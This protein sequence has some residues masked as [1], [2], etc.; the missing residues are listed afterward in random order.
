[1]KFT[2]LMITDYAPW[3][4]MTPDQAAALENKSVPST[5]SC[6]TAEP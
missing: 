1:M 3:Q 5:T 4:D 6:P 2:L